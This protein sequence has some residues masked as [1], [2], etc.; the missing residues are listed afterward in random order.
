MAM[1]LK[2]TGA[3]TRAPDNCR[4]RA[5]VHKKG[6]LKGS[7]VLLHKILLINPTVSTNW[8]QPRSFPVAGWGNKLMCSGILDSNKKKKKEWTV[9][10]Y[11]NLGDPQRNDVGSK[12]PAVRYYLLPTS[13]DGQQISATG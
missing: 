5:F 2:L 3:I 1:S 11:D 7:K 12:Q 8:I 10:M 9:D 13:R 6:K 4:M